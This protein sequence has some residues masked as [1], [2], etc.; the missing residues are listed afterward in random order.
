MHQRIFRQR[1]ARIVLAEHLAELLDRGEQ[2]MRCQMLIAKDQHRIVYKGAIELRR[3]ASS[4]V[5]VR[6]MPRISAPV[7]AE[8][9]AIV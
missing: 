1:E 9:G 2:L 6:S 8:S 7:C 4:T 5:S 3:A